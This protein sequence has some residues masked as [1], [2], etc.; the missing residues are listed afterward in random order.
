MMTQEEYMNVKA[1]HGA[2]WTIKQIAEHLGFHPATVSSWLK[3]G[4][5]PP[6]R[7]VAEDDLVIDARWRARIAGLLAHNAELQG[8]SIMRVIGAEGYEGSYQ[9]LARYLHSVRG[10]TRGAV[11][12]TMPIETTPGEEFQFDWSDCNTFAR[13]WGFVHEL[14]CFGCVLCW[15]RI[16]FWFFAPSIDQHHTLEG[17]VRFFE[18]IG[19]VPALGRTDRMGQLG[20]S[21]SKGF[22]FH[23]LAL[24]FAR[25]YDLAFKACDAGDA[26]RKGKIERPFR[27]LKR[28]FLAEADLDPPEDV[29]EL[30]RRAVRWLDRYLHGVPHGTTGVPPAER[31]ETERHVLGRLPAVRFDTAVR[32]TRRVGRVPLVEWDGVFYS[33]PP[34]VA[35]KVIEVRQ[36]IGYQVIELRFLG[37][38]VALHH[39]VEKGSAP[40]W[41]PEHK[42]AAEAIVLGRRRFGVV[43]PVALGSAMTLDL[44]EGDY[45][46]ALPDLAAM[47]TIGPHPDTTLP[48]DIAAEGKVAGAIDPDG[49]PS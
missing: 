23:P 20:K 15:S 40:Q 16:K 13:R 9:T 39:L 37:Q 14:H 30:N 45:D 4:G 26:K 41:L 11:T 18:H 24:A 29:G 7:T 25:H 43:E 17:L 21:R 5:P 44:E 8:S 3:N 19:G 22:V 48:V 1:L 27:D 12:L 35:G 46:V 10:P 38:M 36:P 6:K 33:A 49:A 2:G 47:G 31:F 34:S 28:S 42:S 32:D